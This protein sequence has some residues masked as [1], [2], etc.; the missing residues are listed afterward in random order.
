MIFQETPLKGA[1]VIDVEKLEDKR[2]FFARAWCEEEFA[3]RG[4]V[5]RMS[6]AS[7]SYSKKKG[8]LRGMHYQ[9][10]PCKEVKL[11]RCIRGKTF[12]VLVDL[13]PDSATFKQ[14][15]ATELDPQS[16]RAI[17]VPW[18]I[19]HGFQ[20][21]KDDT[22]VFYQMSEVYDPDCARGVRWNDPAFGIKWP[23]DER[24]ILERDNTYPDFDPDTFDLPVDLPISG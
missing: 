19:A 7:V 22:E 9:A 3:A 23:P 1:F 17:Y 5:D 16:Y 21:L 15:F 13:R 14:Y 8:T 24:T 12:S 6:Q 4:L 11:V 10:P 18:G 2:G 20:T